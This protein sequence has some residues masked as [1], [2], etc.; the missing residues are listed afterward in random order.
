MLEGIIRESI[1]KKSVKQL[2]R[3][4]YLIANIYGKGVENINCAFKRNEFM[5]Y[6]KQ[7]SSLKFPVKIG[8]KTLEVVVQEYQKHP[9]TSDLLH[10][11]LRVLEKG[12]ES[13]FFV[14]VRTKGTPIGL[15]NKGV[16]I[17]G[18]RRVKVRCS[19][20]NLPDFFEF[21]VTSLDV[22][23]SILARDIP[24]PAGVQIAIEP[25]VAVVGVIK[26]K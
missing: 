23:H 12:L 7:K 11:D 5:K 24:V 22:G 3:D 10:A 14:P 1:D 17:I 4:G 8:A 9:V 19:A 25:H 20:E 15:R 13:N 18:K 26:A 16:M 6:M 2:R 21:D